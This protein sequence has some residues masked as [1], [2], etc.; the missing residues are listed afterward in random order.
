MADIPPSAHKGLALPD[1]H[2]ELEDKGVQGPG[3]LKFE[4]ANTI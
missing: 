4:K 3:L 1:Y 2:E